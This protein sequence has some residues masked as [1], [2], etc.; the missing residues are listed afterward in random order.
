MLEACVVAMR[1]ERS[2]LDMVVVDHLQD[3]VHK[4][5]DLILLEQARLAR[6]RNRNRSG[7]LPQAPIDN[8]A[9]TQAGPSHT[10]RRR[11]R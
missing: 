9:G 7:R 6:N 3:I 8:D 2:W 1:A 10:R 11:N 4:R 5:D